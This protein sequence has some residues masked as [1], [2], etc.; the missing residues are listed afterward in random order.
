MILIDT[1]IW[2]DHIRSKDS[3]LESLLLDGE[4]LCHPLVTG[5]VL[6]G[7]VRDWRTVRRLMEDLPQAVVAREPEVLDFIERHK[8]HGTGIGYVDVHL[9]VSAQLTEEASIWSRDR[10]LAEAARR[11]GLDDT[12][13]PRLQ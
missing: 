8:L 4:V 3:T 10:R 1:S 7:N 12:R 6:V 11:L 9:L 13:F 2:I 5:E